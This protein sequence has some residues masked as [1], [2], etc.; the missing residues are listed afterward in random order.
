MIVT[1]EEQ[2]KWN[3]IIVDILREFI[4][5]CEKY[6]LTY[7]CGGGTAIGAVR[8]HG[9]IPWDDDIDVFMPR[10]DYNR[11]LALK[12]KLSSTK[13]EITTPYDTPN[14]PMYFSKF[15]N[16]N[17]TLVEEAD[18]PCVFGLYIDVFPLDGTSDDLAEASRL[19]EKFRRLQNKME[20][21]STRSTFKEYIRL[22]LKFK[23]WG[24]FI[25]KTYGFFFRDSYRRSLLRQMDAICALYDYEKAKN[26]VVY[27]GVYGDREIYPKAWV[28]SAVEFPFEGLKVKLSVGYD[29]YLR[30]FFGD[31]MQLPPVDKRASHHIKAYF[32]MDERIPV[33]VVMRKIGRKK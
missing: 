30:Q 5:I 3:A 22:L 16:R 15:C 19:K 13:Y 1:P 27:C 2:P 6:H 32:N 20:A 29:K 10:P 14:Y 9:I 4:E 23:E 31:Y 11:F 28:C 7:F 12:D 21:I 17:T 26:V 33:D 8:H 25:R 24:R 18:T